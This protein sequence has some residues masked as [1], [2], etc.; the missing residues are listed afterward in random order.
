MTQEPTPCTIVNINDPSDK[1]TAQFRPKEISIDRNVNWSKHE[2]PNGNSSMLE[3]TGANNPTLSVELF[4]DSFQPLV[5]SPPIKIMDQIRRLESMT[6][7]PE[8]AKGSDRHP[9]Q[10]MFTWQAGPPFKGVIESLSIKYTMFD[11]QGN[12]IR[13]T[14]TVKIKEADEIQLKAK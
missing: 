2:N 8:K 5:K 7:I 10:V 12:P 6:M 11:S 9:P 4:F 14:C 3:F 13:A 1:V